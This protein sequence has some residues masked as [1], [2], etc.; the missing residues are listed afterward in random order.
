MV[1]TE[2]P[3]YSNAIA[4]AIHNLSKENDFSE[5]IEIVRLFADGCGGQH[6]NTVMISMLGYW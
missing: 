1:E 6:K 3:N 5:S 2:S 4:S